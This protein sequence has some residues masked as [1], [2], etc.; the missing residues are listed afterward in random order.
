MISVRIGILVVLKMT[1]KKNEK[2][3]SITVSIL[4]IVKKL[5]LLYIKN[6]R[7]QWVIRILYIDMP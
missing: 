5:V 4:F 3:I 1:S 2:L 6:R 7:G